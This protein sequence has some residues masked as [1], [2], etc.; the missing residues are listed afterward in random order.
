MSSLSKYTIVIL[1]ALAIIFVITIFTT[2][3]VR[4][5]GGLSPLEEE[6]KQPIQVKPPDTKEDEILEP[7]MEAEESRPPQEEEITGEQPSQRVTVRDFLVDDQK[8]EKAM[9]F[10]VICSLP[11]RQPKPLRRNTVHCFRLF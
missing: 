3:S 1:V 8:E 5:I 7:E 11:P 9:D 10:T 6:Y 2:Q 4:D